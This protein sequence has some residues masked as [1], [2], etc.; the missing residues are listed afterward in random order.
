MRRSR[1][2]S[3]YVE[4]S[5]I[6]GDLKTILQT[7]NKTELNIMY[8]LTVKADMASGPAQRHPAIISFKVCVFL[9]DCKIT[10][11]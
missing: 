5:R 10:G 4:C 3:E 9:P 11:Y 2:R 8:V 1:P 7:L 6:H